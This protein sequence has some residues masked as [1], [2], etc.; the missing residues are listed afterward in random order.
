MIFDIPVHSFIIIM[1]CSFLAGAA[2][3]FCLLLI[4]SFIKKGKLAKL[5]RKAKVFRNEAAGWQRIAQDEQ[6]YNGR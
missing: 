1:L 3:A 5:A 4:A 2:G 6:L